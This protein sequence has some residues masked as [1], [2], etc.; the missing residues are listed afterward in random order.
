MAKH[1][2]LVFSA[3][4]LIN[5]IFS[6][7]K[8]NPILTALIFVESMLFYL[9]YIKNNFLKTSLT[10]LM[11]GIL[12]L[13]SFKSGFDNNLF[14][15]TPLE[16]DTQVSRHEHFAK[17]LGKIYKN[18]I[19]INYAK[20]V[21]PIL[22]KFNRNLFSH[23]DFILFFNLGSFFSLSLIPLFL[24]GLYKIFQKLN[25]FLVVYLLIVFIAGGFLIPGGE[26]G[27]LLYIPFFN[28]VVYLGLMQLLRKKNVKA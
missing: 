6:V 23:L 28:L 3:V 18:R 1:N 14:K 11:L 4:V 22:L 15:L 8:Y 27:H 2:L 21:R 13:L 7:Y 19:G 20:N 24:I 16:A 25:K 26:Y 5:L 9:S 12:I 10:F 17:E